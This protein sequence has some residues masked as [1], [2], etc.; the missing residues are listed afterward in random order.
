MLLNLLEEYT[1]SDD[2]IVLEMDPGMA[3]GTGDHETTALCI[4]AL[5]KYIEP[6]TQVLD[7]GCGTGVLSVASV[8]LGA[9]KATAVDLDR[10]AVSI[11]ADNARRNRVDDK[12]EVV[13]GN[14]LDKVKGRFDIAVANI[15]ADVI[16]ELTL[17]IN[18]FLKPN[19]LFI[20]SGIILE[21]LDDVVK[22]MEA[23]GLEVVETKT[24]GE[25]AAVVSRANA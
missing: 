9:E 1:V 10:N 2:E 11:T 20:A 15:I 6:G 17:S 19:G 12:L 8:L 25:W 16:I 23:S 5:D 3:F 18:S 7:I 24:R 22:E 14:L 21:R 4:E 13:H